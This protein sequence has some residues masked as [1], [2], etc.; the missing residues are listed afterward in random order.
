MRLRLATQTG[1]VFLAAMVAVLGAFFWLEYRA[2][3]ESLPDRVLARG[4][5]VA[6]LTAE[7]IAHDVRFARLYQLSETLRKMAARERGDDFLPLTAYAVLNPAGQVLAHSDIRAHPLMTH[8]DAPAKSETLNAD[9]LVIV[10]D[11]VHPTNGRLLGKL[12][13][14]FDPQPALARLSALRT[15]LGLSLLAALAISLMLALGIR[16]KVAR[17]L[18]LLVREAAH[19]GTGRLADL[20]LEDKPW[21]IRRLAEAMREADANIVLANVEARKLAEVIRRAAEAVVITDA[22]GVIEYV[23]PAFERLSGYTLTEAAGQTPRIVKSGEHDDA[24]YAGMWR[25]IT[26][27]QTWHGEFRNRRKDGAIYHVE[28]TIVPLLDAEGGIAGYASVQRDITEQRALEAQLR[29]ADRLESL[30]VLAGGI[31]HDFNNLLTAILGNVDLARN[32]LD[33]SSPALKHL[34]AIGQA[35]QS[36]ADL[37]R[38]MLAYSGKGKFVIQPLD[39]SEMLEGMG[40]LI[41]VSVPKHVRIEQKLAAGLPPVE[42]DIAQMQQVALNLITN[43]AEAIGEKQGTIT[44][45]TGRMHCDAEWLAASLGSDDAAPGD[46]VWL[47]VADT[48][49]GMTPE[50]LERVFDPFFTTKFTGRGLGMSA[51]LGIVRG[52]GGRM[53]IDTQPGRGTRITVA[54]PA[55]PGAEAAAR[56]EGRPELPTVSASGAA[57][58]V[59]DEAELRKVGAAMLLKMG[60]SEVVEAADGEEA[61]RRFS[62]RPEA[63]K[64]VLLDMTMP[65]MDGQTCFAELRRVR[66]DA[67]VILTSG[68]SEEEI[69]GRF[70]NDALAGFVQKPFRME[71]LARAVRRAL[72]GDDARDG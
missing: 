2:A 18:N 5:D 8:L 49:C 35:G 11:I 60:F 48:G 67:R 26:Q 39:L 58:V 34:D 37:C 29:H 13:L 28:Q 63:F 19:I 62:E 21:E 54:F 25:A 72:D 38:Q 32:K 14:R 43:A 4:R 10:H 27:G 22:D 69:A 20:R 66:P 68:Y 9:E 59:D 33:E 24:Y 6:A 23:N 44:L 46:Y 16:R 3:S 70:A 50:V 56:G 41:A 57:L 30:G 1:L 52:H 61:V 42:A 47:E 64:L 40:K 71:S 12:V 65:R 7:A 36:A 17:P 53:R 31:A 55:A 45:A 15:R 51:M